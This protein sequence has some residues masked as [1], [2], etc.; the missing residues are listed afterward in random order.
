MSVAGWA[1]LSPPAVEADTAGVALV[2]EAVVAG[3]CAVVDVAA[4]PPNRDD[5]GFDA[6]PVAAVDNWLPP[7]RPPAVDVVD[8]T[9]AGAVDTVDLL[10]N[11]PPEE[12]LVVVVDGAA[13]AELALP[14]NRRLV[15]VEAEPTAPDVLLA[16]GFA[17]NSEPAEPAAAVVPLA[18]P[19][20]LPADAPDVDAGL[21]PNR[22]AAEEPVLA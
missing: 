6:A 18:P 12:A 3:G 8:G 19:N 20:K 16:A 1:P 7:K 11:R 15:V 13:A 22:P 4:P 21:F 10:P 2:D 14:P 9:V 17:P 5:A